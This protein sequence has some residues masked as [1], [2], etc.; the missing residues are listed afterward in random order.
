M[1][2]TNTSIIISYDLQLHPHEVKLVRVT[3][4]LGD[5]EEFQEFDKTQLNGFTFYDLTPNQ[6]YQVVTDVWDTNGVTTINNRT[7]I[8]QD[9]DG[10]INIFDPKKATV[11]P[12]RP[13]LQGVEVLWALNSLLVFLS[14]F[15][16]LC[17]KEKTIIVRTF[18]PY[19]L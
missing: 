17:S 8:T 18:W 6:T 19:V 2:T 7:V 16:F 5:W 11:S 9:S 14:H 10:E 13:G 1:K 12:G 3:I 4:T 15:H